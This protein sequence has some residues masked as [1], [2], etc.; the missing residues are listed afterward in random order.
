[1]RVDYRS[2][3]PRTAAAFGRGFSVDSLRTVPAALGTTAVA[4]TI[5]FYPERMAPA[6]PAFAAYLDKYL[7]P[8]KYYL[9][10]TDRSNTAF[11][12]ILGHDRALRL[13]Y[14]VQG[15]QLVSL[16]GPPR[17]VPDSLRLHADVSLK[18]KMFR[19]GFH[20]LVSDVV[21]T[22]TPHERAWTIVAQQEPEWDL[23]LAAE[24]LLRT[25]LHRPFE[26]AGALFRIGVRDTAGGQTLLVRRTRLDVQESAIMHFIGALGAH[27]VG[28]LANRTE[29][30][31]DQFLRDGFLALRA[32]VRALG[33]RWRETENAIEP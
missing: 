32:D 8:A 26:G 14:R 10:L 27:A 30:E 3:F 24:H 1:M 9:T 16:Y 19:V 17:P 11:I 4:L 25:P 18:V 22:R 31:E 23:P 20:N 28:E 7:K 29:S 6:Y 15:G 13:R 33:R 2:A 5:G 12:E 21:V